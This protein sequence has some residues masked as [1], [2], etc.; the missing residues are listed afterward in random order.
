MEGGL[1]YMLMLIQHSH[2]GLRGRDDED[3][4]LENFSDKPISASHIWQIIRENRRMC[5]QQ[6]INLQVHWEFHHLLGQRSVRL[7]RGYAKK[8]FYITSFSVVTH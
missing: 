6:E 4:Q 1:A 3:V 2:L 5:R 8:I 7:L